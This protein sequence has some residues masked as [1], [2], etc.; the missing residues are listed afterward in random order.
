MSIQTRTTD[1]A[2]ALGGHRVIHFDRTFGRE[3]VKLQPGD[4]GATSLDLIFS[5]VLGSCVA[6]CLYD[7]VARI[8]GM[9]HFLLPGSTTGDQGSRYGM[10]AMELL[11]NEMLKRGASKP[12][13]AAKV[14]GGAK[15]LKSLTKA[16]VGSRNADF[17]EQYLQDENI[18][19]VGSDLRAER[20][21]K[22]IFFAASGQALVRNVGSGAD[23]SEWQEELE[24]AST[25]GQSAST[26]A[27]EVEL[28]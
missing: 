26:S 24:Y 20:P 25:V 19:I 2:S 6:A 21:R 8:G 10:Y 3:I 9:N 14:F 18:P 15:V 16:D 23:N 5:T 27:G 17:I 4:Y 7:P 12:R 1:S 13:I 28:F 11:I 22:V